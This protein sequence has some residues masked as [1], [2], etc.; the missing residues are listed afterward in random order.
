MH[1]NADMGETIAVLPGDGIGQE[2]MPAALAVLDAIGDFEYREGLIGKQA[3]EAT[4]S[5]FPPQTEE[6]VQN[7]RAVLLGAVDGPHGGPTD[8]DDPWPEAGRRKLLQTMQAY[9]NI[10]PIRFMGLPGVPPF[11]P[12]RIR[13]TDFIIIH[14]LQGGNTYGDHSLIEGIA[15]DIR[16]YHAPMITAVGRTAFSL[17]EERAE[18]YGRTP[19]VTSVDE[20]NGSGTSRLW[21]E[22]ITAL[23]ED[24]YQEV[25]LDHLAIADA[26]Y[27][28]IIRPQQFDVIVTTGELG[29]ILS[30][31]AVAIPGS[32][33]LVPSASLNQRG[34]GVFEPVH[35]AAPDIAGKGIVNPI[36]MILS[37]AMALRHSLGKVT[38]AER[39]EAAVEKALRHGFWTADLR[40]N[41]SY[42]REATTQELTAVIVQSLETPSDA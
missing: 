37:A 29:D 25:R 23:Q 6:N 21:R 16:E 35:D 31:T 22:V 42:G 1:Y 5:P 19:H 7:V 4:G 38:E 20:A 14:E 15:L 32:K 27:E 39:I 33:W 11:D 24:E 3:V 34:E 8:P 41:N 40:E 28:M 36:A 30:S 17:A 18:E 9:A 2:V 26:A 13:N 12:S 10:R